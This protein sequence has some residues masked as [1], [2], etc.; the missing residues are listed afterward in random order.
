[1]TNKFSEEPFETSSRF[2]ASTFDR[3]SLASALDQGLF[4]EGR[5]KPF[6]AYKS[7]MSS[8]N[9][10]SK[11]FMTASETANTEMTAHNETKRTTKNF[12][13]SPSMSTTTVRFQVLKRN[14]RV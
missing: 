1:M 9:D 14:I 11:G 6:R 4:V 3:I 7:S 2:E 5:A 8:Y 12:F 10:E 13:I